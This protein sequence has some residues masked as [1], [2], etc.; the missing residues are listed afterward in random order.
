MEAA[1]SCALC[2]SGDVMQPPMAPDHGSWEGNRV[3]ALLT[4][5]KCSFVLVKVF[6]AQGKYPTGKRVKAKPT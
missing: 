3:S 5:E 2:W 1:Q 6:S 4:G